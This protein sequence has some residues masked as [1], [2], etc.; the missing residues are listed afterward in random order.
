MTNT[1]KVLIIGLLVIDLGVGG[2]LLFPKDDQPPATTGAAAGDAATVTGLDRPASTAH[3]AGGSVL[4]TK[5]PVSST[6]KLAMALPA[7]PGPAVAPAAAVVSVAPAAPGV[8]VP[9]VGPLVSVAP[10]APGVSVAPVAPGT[11]GATGST[12]SGPVQ[13]HVA[14]KPRV[15][16]HAP[17][18]VGVQK[19]AHPKSKPVTQLA[20]QDHSHKR[21]SAH[22]R[23]SKLVSS[24]MT[25]QLV[26][27]SAK[28]DPSLPPPPYGH[29]GQTGSGSHPVSAAMTDDLVRES[30]KVTPASGFPWKSEKH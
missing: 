19:N 6:D 30:S 23:D 10:A 21:D 16:S 17:T 9:P 20:E 28:P 11:N 29:P 26:R 5:P 7:D 24:A 22:R 14:S 4:V 25:A 12:Y 18:A 2:Y 8:P 13:T 15:T 27:E 1:G 3:V